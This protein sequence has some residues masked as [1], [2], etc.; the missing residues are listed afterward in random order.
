M[1]FDVELASAISHVEEKVRMLD[2]R[3][4]YPRALTRG[5]ACSIVWPFFLWLFQIVDGRLSQYHAA[6]L[7]RGMALHLSAEVL[8]AFPTD[9]GAPTHTVRKHGGT[10]YVVGPHSA[11][12]AIGTAHEFPQR[13]WPSTA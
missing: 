8:A 13:C 12:E 3:L 6:V 7:H 1:Q 5:V 11:L 2:V 10:I 9:T 4:Q